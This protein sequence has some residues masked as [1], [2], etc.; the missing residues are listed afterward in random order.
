VLCMRVLCM[1]VLCMR[2][3][4]M[5][6]LCMRVLCMRVLCMRVRVRIN[7]CACENYN[8]RVMRVCVHACECSSTFF[9]RVHVREVVM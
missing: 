9:V 6:V 1:R 5:R 7:V 4:C 8:V 3:L 2:V